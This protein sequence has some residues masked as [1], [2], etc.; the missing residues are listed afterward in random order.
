MQPLSIQEFKELLKPFDLKSKVCVAVSGGA[1][2]MALTLL[3][4]HVFGK[5]LHTVSIDHGLRDASAHELEQVHAWLTQR[6]I[7][8]HIIQWHHEEPITSRIQER[9]RTARYGL[10][11]Q[12]CKENACTTLLT[13]HHALD[14]WETFM[15]RLSKGSGLQG[16]CAMSPIVQ[17]D[18][19]QH[20]R[21]LLTIAPQ[22]LKEILKAYQQDFIEDPSNQN[23]QF[24]RIAW[25]QRYVDFEMMGLDVLKVQ[26]TIDNLTQAHHALE[27]DVMPLLNEPFL[28]STH[29]ENIPAYVIQKWI[30]KKIQDLMQAPYPPSHKEIQRIYKALCDKTSTCA[31]LGKCKII[32]HQNKIWIEPENRPGRSHT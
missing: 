32:K 22:R 10:L 13:A 29:L 12:W 3:C 2:S 14:Q 8:H 28:T 15:M 16:L 27:M 11:H 25:R 19:G 30:S 17:Y 26:K 4:S 7:Q 6:G 23:N 9:A 31:T 20:I 5:R 1:D 18:W 21:P 24:E